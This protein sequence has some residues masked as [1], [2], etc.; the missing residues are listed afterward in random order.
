NIRLPRGARRL[1]HA[2]VPAQDLVHRRYRRHRL[3]VA[4]QAIRNL[5]RSPGRVGIAQCH[6]LLLDRGRGALR[7][8][9][10]PPRPVRQCRIAR[11]VALNPLVAGLGADAELSTQLPHVRLLLLGKHHELSSLVHERHLSPRHGSSPCLTNPADFDVS[12][13]S[14]NRCKLCPRTEQ[15][16]SNPFFI[17]LATWIASPRLSPGAD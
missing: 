10:R 15:Q 16:R 14:P 6:D 2:I 11:I 3:P 1:R 17:P 5:A 13:M 9:M 4:L 7:T 12:T 8:M